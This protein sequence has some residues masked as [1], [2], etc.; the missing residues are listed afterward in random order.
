MTTKTLDL[1]E[2][3]TTFG[4][5]YDHARRMGADRPLSHRF[6]LADVL[7]EIE[8]EIA[9]RVDAVK[10]ESEKALADLR[11]EHASAIA[12]ERART[13][14]AQAAAMLPPERLRTSTI[15]ADRLRDLPITSSPRYTATRD[16]NE[17]VVVLDRVTG[18]HAI[19]LVLRNAELTAHGLNRGT[20]D[21]RE[22][23]WRAPE[24]RFVSR[25]S[26]SP[27]I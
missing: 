14:A 25:R 21:P 1:S 18:K 5:T 19:F 2:L 7:G 9:K 20:R 6:A 4:S 3:M 22:I 23:A 26:Y 27:F 16:V 13:S 11:V 15:T 10:A 24:T 17:N 12:T 8:V